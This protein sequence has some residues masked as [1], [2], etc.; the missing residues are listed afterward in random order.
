MPNQGFRGVQSPALA[1][2]KIHVLVI[3]N[4]GDMILCRIGPDGGKASLSV[5]GGE[6]QV[7]PRRVSWGSSHWRVSDRHDIALP[8]SRS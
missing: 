7:R 4:S 1:R 3:D 5:P 6:H 8:I 2:R